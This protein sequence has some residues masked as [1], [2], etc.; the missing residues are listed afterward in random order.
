MVTVWLIIGALAALQRG[1]FSSD[2]SEK[3]DC[4]RF[5]TTIVTIVTGP[6]NYTGL[7]PKIGCPEPSK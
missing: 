6:L 5:S 1:Y 7:N 3:K 4:A 2:W